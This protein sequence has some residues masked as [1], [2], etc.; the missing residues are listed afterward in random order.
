MVELDSYI[1][2]VLVHHPTPVR[3]VLFFGLYM[4]SKG[5]TFGCSTGYIGV[6][7]LLQA[8]YWIPSVV[9]FWTSSWGPICVHHAAIAGEASLGRIAVERTART[10]TDKDRK[11][12]MNPMLGV[13]FDRGLPPT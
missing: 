11:E 5:R 2:V 13:P 4:D 8:L 9:K 7:L 6:P 1:V 12:G 10:C 3:A